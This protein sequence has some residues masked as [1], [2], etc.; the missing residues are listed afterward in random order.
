MRDSQCLKIFPKLLK[1]GLKISY[2]DPTGEK[3]ELKNLLFKK[4]S[5]EILKN[6][7]LVVIHTEWDE[8]RSLDFVKVKS[9]KLIIFDMRNLYQPNSF[10][11][12]N[13]TYYSIGRPL[14]IKSLI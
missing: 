9:K 1:K 12:K 5:D 8:F 6:N 3:K 7:D 14:M 13:V 10:S 2:Y 4:S 11:N